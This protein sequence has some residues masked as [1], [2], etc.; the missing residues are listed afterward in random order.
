MASLVIPL[1]PT[2]HI[3]LMRSHGTHY[4]CEQIWKKYGNKARPCCCIDHDCS[5]EKIALLQSLS[6]RQRAVWEFSL[7]YMEKKGHLPHQEEIVAGINGGTRQNIMQ[8][9]RAMVKKG[10]MVRVR[11]TEKAHRNYL[12]VSPGWSKK[13]V[14]K[15]LKSVISLSSIKTK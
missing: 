4:V 11:S 8:A 2:L 13:Y 6:E 1:I 10:W 14:Q 5:T 7:S 12:P 3:H 15:V 9:V